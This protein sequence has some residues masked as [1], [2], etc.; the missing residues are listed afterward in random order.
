MTYQD[1][2]NSCRDLY[3]KKLYSKAVLQSFVNKGAL[4]QEEFNA[5]IDGTPF[6]WEVPVD[7]QVE[8]EIQN[9]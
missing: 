3:Q 7:Q 9:A 6:S 1:F 2:C 5:I 4:N 8:G